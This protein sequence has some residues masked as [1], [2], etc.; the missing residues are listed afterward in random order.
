[1]IVRTAPRGTRRS[2]TRRTGSWAQQHLDRFALVHL[3]VAGGSLVELLDP[4]LARAVHHR[5][6]HQAAA[7][8][9][10]WAR[11]VDSSRCASTCASSSRALPSTSSTTS[12]PAAQRSGGAAESASS[13]SARAS[14]AGSP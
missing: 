3:A 1:M 4:Y 11:L 13:T 8:A 10:S 12:S 7:F 5:A 2:L 6:A 9:S 14:L